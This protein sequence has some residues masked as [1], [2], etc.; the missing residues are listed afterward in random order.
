M[1]LPVS[2]RELPELGKKLAGAM[3]RAPVTSSFLGVLLGTTIVQRHFVSNDDA[4][5]RWASTNIDNMTTA[6]I[7]SLLASALLL[8]GGYWVVYAVALGGSLGWLEARVGT[9]RAVGVFLS[10]HVLATL[11]TEGGVWIGVNLG[12]V[13][14]AARAQ[15]DV[16][17]SYGMWA[18]IAA[19][20]VLLPR[21]FRAPVA[22]LLSL[23]VV[24]PIISDYNMTAAGHVLSFAI[25]L[26]WWPVLQRRLRVR[27]E[28]QADG[29][30]GREI[31][32]SH[33]L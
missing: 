20:A 12:D 9:L 27:S 21:R 15:L 14:N 3:R 18:S 8:P 5:L 16:G 7:R 13:P 6:P 19:A 4:L 22:A 31:E 2:A 25:G 10:A 28:T 32:F 1:S 29:P 30:R 26:A 33:S 11:V 24:V 23:G 17:V